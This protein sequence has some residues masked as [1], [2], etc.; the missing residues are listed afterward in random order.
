MPT[1]K[2]IRVRSTPDWFT[3]YMSTAGAFQSDPSDT[4]FLYTALYNNSPNGYYLFVYGMMPTDDVNTVAPVYLI[5]GPLGSFAAPG[6]RINPSLGAP[7]GNVTTLNNGPSAISLTPTTI[8]AVAFAGA[9]VQD[10]P[11]FVLPP[12]W[13]VAVGGTLHTTIAG[14]GFW[15]IPMVDSLGMQ[16]V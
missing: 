8:M 16:A 14:C 11:L 10:M 5:N 13:S 12:N 7:P 2:G 9:S 15:Y 3:T 4:N 1:P 6:T